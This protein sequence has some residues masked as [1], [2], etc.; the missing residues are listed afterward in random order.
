VIKAE[1]QAVLKTLTKDDFQNA[2]KNGKS[3]WG[4]RMRSERDYF[5]SDG[6]Q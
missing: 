4:Q 1:S 6:G 3:S 2:F 5:E